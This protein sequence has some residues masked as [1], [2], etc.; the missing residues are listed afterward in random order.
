MVSL[1]SVINVPPVANATLSTQPI[2]VADRVSTRVTPV[3]V[4]APVSIDRVSDNNAQR[5]VRQVTSSV[6][7]GNAKA[8]SADSSAYLTQVISQSQSYNSSVANAQ[9]FSR[10]APALQYNTLVSY[11]FV[12]YKPS[13]AG[14]PTNNDPASPPASAGESFSA[15]AVA[16]EYQAYNQAQSRAASLKAPQT[17]P[18]V[19]SG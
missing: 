6:T 9:A 10:F 7:Q 4:S 16:N 18:V 3:A 17:V 1:S 14:I 8:A 11:S 2:A 13:N 19:I 5:D 12:K 15:T